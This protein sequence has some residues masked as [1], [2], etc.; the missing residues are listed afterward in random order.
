MRK[1]LAV[2]LLFVMFAAVGMRAKA[3][4][5]DDYWDFEQADGTYAYGFSRIKVSM[6][7]NWYQKT[8]VVLGDGGVTASFY[9]KASYD[10]YEAEGMTGGLLFT[11]GASVN[12][13]FQELPD[14]VYLGFDEEEAMNYYALL[15]TDYQAYI[16]DEAIRN[17]YDELW[18]SVEDVLASAVVKGSEQFRELYK[19]DDDS[20]TQTLSGGWEVMEDSAVTEQAQAIFDLAMPDNDRMDY[21]AVA[22]LA[23]QVVAGKNYCFLCRT[24]IRDSDEMPTY[25]LVYIW[26]DLMGDAHILEVKDIEFGLSEMNTDQTSPPDTVQTVETEPQII[27]SGDYD[28]LIFGKTATIAKYNGDAKEV[29]VP[30]AINEYQVTAIG[31]EAFRYRKLKSVSIPGSICTIGRQAFEYCEIT[32]YLSLPQNVTIS[33]DAFSY[34]VLPTVVIIPAGA[35]VEKCAFSYCETVEEV[36]IEPGVL[37]KGR[38]F[39]YCGDITRILCAEGSRLEKN[40][41]EYCRK[42][43]KAILCGDVEVEEESFAACG[44]AEVMEEAADEYDALKKAAHDGSLGGHKDSFPEEEKNLE[45]INS[46]A[47]LDGVTVTLEKATA[48]RMDSRGFEYTFSGTIENNSDEGIMQIIYTFA[49]IDENGEEY[50]SFGIVYDGEDTALAQHTK[51][52]FF[53]DNIKWGKQSVPAAVAIGISSV[54]TEAELPAAHVPQAGEYLYQALGDEKLANIKEEPPVELSFHVDQ[55]GYGRTATFT[56]GEAL[57]RAVELFC[58]IRIGEESGEWVTD[59][60]NGIRLKWTDGTYTGISL[61]LRNLEYRVHSNIHTYEL[62][63]LGAFWSYCADYLE[64][65]YSSQ[66]D[67][68][69][70]VGMRR[71]H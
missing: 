29:L 10:A 54:K 26:Q 61:N 23:T 43:E 48:Q 67:E 44:D 14:F 27:T 25:Q 39:G 56:D 1:I 41:F 13:D 45:I 7:K 59:N 19:T 18:D 38:S 22:L 4:T 24:S 42:L 8:R 34:A 55:G 16:G 6:D 28:Y 57:D 51:T 49:L 71:R 5:F 11:I 69:E 37:L 63:N 2:V 3:G 70:S 17:E 46:P 60:Y 15:P 31:P 20:M 66:R 33:E 40:A 36:C 58:D 50:R 52:E 65:D 12:T 47:T 64:E 62:D 68:P 30:S 21:E 9:H 32:D 53:H 35:T